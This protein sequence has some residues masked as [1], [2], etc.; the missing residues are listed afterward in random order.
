MGARVSVCCI[1]VLQGF[2]RFYT[3]RPAALRFCDKTLT[4]KFGGFR[5][6]AALLDGSKISGS[7]KKCRFTSAPPLRRYQEAGS[8]KISSVSFRLCVKRAPDGCSALTGGVQVNQPGD[9]KTDQK[10]LL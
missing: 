7:R 5:V 9:S 4:G 1:M 2:T 3:D 6:A 10:R 8:S